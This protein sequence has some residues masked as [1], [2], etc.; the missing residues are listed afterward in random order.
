M[1]IF[2]KLEQLYDLYNTNKIA[3]G[4][5]KS[6]LTALFVFS[7]WAYWDVASHYSWGEVVLIIYALICCIILMWINNIICDCVRT[8]SRTHK[9]GLNVK[10][11]E[12]FM[13]RVAYILLVGGA[14]F[15]ELSKVANSIIKALLP[16]ILYLIDSITPYINAIFEIAGMFV[17]NNW[18]SI[19]IVLSVAVIIYPFVRTVLKEEEC[20][21]GKRGIIVLEH[22]KADNDR[23]VEK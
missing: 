5:M 22:K 16:F 21:K 6:T 1:N 3:R 10:V 13:S 12:Q 11:Y 4:L 19:L 17:S 9:V 18:H 7:L 14:I 15:F 23:K 20:V 2:Q 8:H